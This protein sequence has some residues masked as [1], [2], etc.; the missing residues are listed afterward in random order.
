MSILDKLNKANKK[1]E[2]TKQLIK[3]GADNDCI[4]DYFNLLDNDEDRER[5]M[6]YFE[7]KYN[8]KVNQW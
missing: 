6:K 5:A 2:E 1:H 8:E 3:Y 4:D 7:D